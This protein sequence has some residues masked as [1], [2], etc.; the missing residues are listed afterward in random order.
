MLSRAATSIYWMSRYIERA[1][2]IARIIHVNWHL[3]LGNLRTAE[4]QWQPLVDIT[5]DSDYFIEKYGEATRENVIQFLVSDREY[6]NSIVSCL[7]MARENARSVRELIPSE[8]WEHINTF[9]FLVRDTTV[10]WRPNVELSEF[11]TA[12]RKRSNEFVGLSLT[13]MMHDEG[14][15][16]SR[17]GRM[18]ERADKTSRILDVKYFYMLPRAE[19]VGGPVDNIQWLALLQSASALQQYRRQH[20][21]ITFN[22]VVAFLLLDATFPRAVRYCSDRT[23]D[24]LHSITGTPRGAYVRPVERECGRLCADLAYAHSSEIVDQGL[25]DYIDSLQTRLNACG[26][27]IHEAFFAP[28]PVN[29]VEAPAVS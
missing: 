15:H 17:L 22:G 2:N 8:M 23:L 5:A 9:Y 28:R 27:A 12:I 19:E 21:A 14:W 29:G 4:E 18:L 25:H 6:P 11:L 16:F 26:E 13:T 10:A 7:S 3:S 20:G 1:E 24:S